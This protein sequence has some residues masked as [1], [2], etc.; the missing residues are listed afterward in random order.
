MK[1]ILFLILLLIISIN[2]FSY[3]EL[4]NYD[5]YLLFK[6]PQNF[7]NQLYT[8]IS[9]FRYLYSKEGAGQES[10][11]EYL[12]KNLSSEEISAANNFISSNF[13]FVSNDNLSFSNFLWINPVQDIIKFLKT[14]NGYIIT[15]YNNREKLINLIKNLFSYDV[16]YN[17]GEYYIKELNLKIF[18]IAGHTIFYNQDFSLEKIF[19]MLDDFNSLIL[20]N[21]NNIFISFKNNKFNYYIEQFQN[22]YLSHYSDSN[23]GTATINYS[24]KEILIDINSPIKVIKN[25]EF[26]SSFKAF[27][28]SIIFLNLNSKNEIYNIAETIFIPQDNYSKDSLK[29]ILNCIENNGNIYL[30]EY[31]SRKANGIS[32]IIPGKVDIE[33]IDKKIKNWG[34]DK[35]T[36]GN[37]YYYDIYYKNVGTPVYLYINDNQLILSSI[38]PSLMKYLIVSSKKF[39]NIKIFNSNTIP[40]NILYIWYSNINAFFEE[41]IGNSIPG[42]FLIIN[43]SNNEKFIEKIILR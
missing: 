40:K 22:K 25:S 28:D 10:L 6:N 20:S 31:F 24:D 3:K 39:S 21:K 4:D 1:K 41:Y 18:F 13:L 9:F 29:F 30:S 37:Y 15:D 12:L 5:F 19:K 34:I 43:A 26:D 16:E 23:I 17:N 8:N 33:K 11:Y 7:Y 27:G 32:I 2:T 42:E 35:K 38:S 36:L 14:F